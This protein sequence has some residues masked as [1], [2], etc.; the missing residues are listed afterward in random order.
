MMVKRKNKNRFYIAWILLLVITPLFVVK[1]FHYHASPNCSSE[2]H[3]IHHER[4]DQSDCDDCPICQFFLSPF[5]EATSFNFFFT[6]TLIFC[7]PVIYS[8]KISCGLSYSHHLRA[9]PVI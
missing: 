3:H 6:Q 7:E 2:I 9:P 1:S 8:D 4:D 5:T